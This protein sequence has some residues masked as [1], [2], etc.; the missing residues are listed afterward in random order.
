[1]PIIIAL[2]GKR[3]V[4]KD[5]VAK[6][7]ETLH[8]FIHVKVAQKLKETIK[9]MFDL[10]DENVEGSIKDD[11]DDRY[12][13]SP[14]QIMQFVGTEIGQFKLQELLPN[15]GRTFWIKS[16]CNHIKNNKNKNFVISDVRFIHEI[17]ELCKNFSNVLV[18]KIERDTGFTDIH[19]SEQECDN[20]TA[21]HVVTNNSDINALYEQVENIIARA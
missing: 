14:R 10:Q 11:I 2:V 5:V 9:V 18:L 21:H 1:M 16:L 17:N 13:V 20:I 6:Y 15:I 12:G 7:L 19:I 4:G 3:R 8:G